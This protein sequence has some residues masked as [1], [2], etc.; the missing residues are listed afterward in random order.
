MTTKIQL[1]EQLVNLTKEINDLI[2]KTR[3]DFVALCSLIDKREII[4]VKLEGRHY[5]NFDDLR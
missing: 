2:Y 3:A 4:K 1:E 5:D